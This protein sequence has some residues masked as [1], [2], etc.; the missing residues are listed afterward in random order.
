MYGESTV[1]YL[2]PSLLLTLLHICH[3]YIFQNIKLSLI[4]DKDSPSKYKMQ[5]L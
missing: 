3:I 4:L 1:L 2:P 5:F